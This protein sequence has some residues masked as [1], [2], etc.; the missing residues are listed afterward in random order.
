MREKVNNL[1]LQLRSNDDSILE[2]SV[3][4]KTNLQYIPFSTRCDIL[5]PVILLFSE[6]SP[7][8]NLLCS[9][10][11]N[12]RKVQQ[13]N[14]L[15]TEKVFKKSMSEC[16]MDTEKTDSFQN[17]NIHLVS[18]KTTYD[19][20]SANLQTNFESVGTVMYRLED[21]V[22]NLNTLVKLQNVFVSPIDIQ[23][24]TI[25]EC[26]FGC[27]LS[28]EEKPST[29]SKVNL[30]NFQKLLHCFSEWQRKM[31]LEKDD[32]TDL[33][34][35][36]GMPDITKDYISLPDVIQEAHDW[37]AFLTDFRMCCIE[38]NHRLELLVR[39]ALGYDID[40]P[41]PLKKLEA[42]KIIPKESTV[43][44]PMDCV[45]Y[46]QLFC[47]IDRQF[48]TEMK[49]YSLNMQMAK[50]VYIRTTW[51][52]LLRRIAEKIRYQTD[53]GEK[54][55]CVVDAFTMLILKEQDNEINFSKLHSIHKN[56]LHII[57]DVIFEND[58]AASKLTNISRV[59]LEQTIHD[60]PIGL[61]GKTCHVYTNVSFFLI[62]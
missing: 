2:T 54:D 62:F 20:G 18:F 30:F 34:E 46:Y 52:T 5:L 39:L 21:D 32:F 25:L 35:R 28:G 43:Y 19:D 11:I 3:I 47:N 38:G 48:V 23:D 4:T 22:T 6:L 44:K 53:F 15:K 17:S 50:T 41:A 58:P 51:Q 60:Q 10:E 36:L 13:K 42:P 56:L 9:P 55:E 12:F 26:I 59:D 8:S 29:G 16:V 57:N 24:I 33:W 31:Y 40:V 1:L 7:Q 14:F 49:K 37:F 45:Y 61:L 27:N